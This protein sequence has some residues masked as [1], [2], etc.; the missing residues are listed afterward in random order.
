MVLPKEIFG[1]TS[2][3]SIAY[4]IHVYDR[5]VSYPGDDWNGFEFAT[6]KY[7]RLPLL[8]G[9]YGDPKNPLIIV[10]HGGPGGDFQYLKEL[11]RLSDEYHILFYDQRGSGRS[12]RNDHMIFTIESF[13]EDA[14]SMI[15]VHSNGKR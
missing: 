4:C 5:F 14:R 9:S 13:L 7:Q 6:D 2:M 10:L 15:R 11:R 3:P 12:D 8:Y 1:C